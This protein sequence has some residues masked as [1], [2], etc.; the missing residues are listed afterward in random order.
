MTIADQTRPDALGKT[1]TRFSLV[2]FVGLGVA[3]FFV[4]HAIRLRD[5]GALSAQSYNAV[6]VWIAALGVWGL[7][8]SWLSLSGRGRS[9]RFLTLLP[10]LWVPPFMVFATVAAIA[11]FPALR[12]AFMTLASGI[13]DDQFILLQVIRIAAIGSIIKTSLGRLPPPFGFGTGIPDFLFAVSAV[14]MLLT[15][16]YAGLGPGI[17]IAWNIV[18]ALIFIAA[19][20]IMQ[21]CLPGPLQIFRREPDGRELLDFP[22]FLAPAVFGPVLLIGNCLHAAKYVLQGM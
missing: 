5:T 16:A 20:V 4:A 8:M 17:L 21:L 2:P 13:P 9:P 15:G 1:R 22:L 12:S 6:L 19:A 3:C 10:G 14:I 18:G 11:L 7:L